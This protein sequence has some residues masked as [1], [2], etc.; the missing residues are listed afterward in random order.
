MSM[1]LPR[2]TPGTN[3]LR[4][5]AALIPIIES[6]LVA[7]KIST[8]RA[9]LMA[10]FCEWTVENPAGDPVSIKLAEAIGNGLKR[11]KNTIDSETYQAKLTS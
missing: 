7:S 1:K 5:T 6:G 8:E 3:R 2:A 9:A 11:I 4:A 10:S